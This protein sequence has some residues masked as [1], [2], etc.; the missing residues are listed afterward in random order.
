MKAQKKFPIKSY[1]DEEQEQDKDTYQ[2]RGKD[3][4]Q[5]VGETEFSPQRR[6]VYSKSKKMR[7]NN[8]I[9]E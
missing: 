7:V 1:K 3:K 8:F 4:P 9:G 2:D 5:E 6:S